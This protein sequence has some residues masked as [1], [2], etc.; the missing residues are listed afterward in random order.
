MECASLVCI[1]ENT[2]GNSKLDVIFIYFSIRICKDMS[3]SNCIIVVNNTYKEES[4]KIINDIHN[5][6][7][8]I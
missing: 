7:F 2:T 5:N 3:A 4:E 1:Y 6:L 8:V